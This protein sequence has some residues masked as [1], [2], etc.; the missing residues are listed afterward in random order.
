M[1]LTEEEKRLLREDMNEAARKMDELLDKK[2][3]K[4]SDNETIR[5]DN[6]T[7]NSRGNSIK[8]HSR[9]R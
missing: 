8:S 4:E 2:E 6:D 1:E 3:S 7:S 5:D 9:V